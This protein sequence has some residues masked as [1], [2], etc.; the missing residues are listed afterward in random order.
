MTTT[1]TKRQEARKALIASLQASIEGQVETL[2]ASEAW[3]DYLNYL[4]SFHEYSMRNVLLIRG[5]FPGASQ[6][7]GF[8]QWQ[9]KGR[10]VRKGEKAIKIFGYAVKRRED[11]SEDTSDSAA[12]NDEQP[13]PHVYFPLLS[14]FDISQTDPI[15]GAPQPQV[16]RQL[17]GE[18]HRGIY[19]KC[20]EFITRKGWTVTRKEIPGTANGY[21]TIDDTHQIVI[22]SALSPAQA[23]KTLIHETAHALLH[24][25]ES[26]EEYL[27]HRGLKEV[28][29]ESVAYVVA[30]ALG[31]DTTDY[32]IGYVAGWAGGKPETIRAAAE[33]VRK[34]ANT[35]VKA[36]ETKEGE[37]THK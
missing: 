11:D 21:A 27:E 29:A 10:Q 32:S 7:A 4:R 24:S 36:I 26:R 1:A 37:D 2:T 35:I 8:K 6:V 18:D 3:T 30:G 9:T 23:A 28:E 17:T 5:Q 33:N 16:A 20:S 25:K 13:E 22:D 31:L 12:T 34:T 15:E 14:V 19:A